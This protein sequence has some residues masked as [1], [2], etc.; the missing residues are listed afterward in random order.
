MLK[1]TVQSFFPALFCPIPLPH[2]KEMRNPVLIPQL[3]TEEACRGCGREDRT[4][5]L[6]YHFSSAVTAAQARALC[7]WVCQR[8]SCRAKLVFLEGA[9]FIQFRGTIPLALTEI[10]SD[11]FSYLCNWKWEVSLEVQTNTKYHQSPVLKVQ[12]QTCL[13]IFYMRV[14]SI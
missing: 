5:S 10:T 3:E 13:I 1:H 2:N 12:G 8:R 9:E 4:A 11:V 14:F 6:A 7:L